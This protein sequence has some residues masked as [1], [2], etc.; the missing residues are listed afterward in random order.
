MALHVSQRM[1][2]ELSNLRKVIQ[3]VGQ[4]QER[5]GVCQLAFLGLNL[6]Q[7]QEK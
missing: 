5:T 7:E 3:S 1:T 6:I 4:D 2:E